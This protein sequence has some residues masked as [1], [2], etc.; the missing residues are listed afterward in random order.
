MANNKK[1]PL[2]RSHYKPMY[3]DGFA[4]KEWHPKKFGIISDS[5]GVCDK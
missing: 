4:D 2:V 1:I 5:F 3:G